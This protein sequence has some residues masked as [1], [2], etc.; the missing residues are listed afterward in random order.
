MKIN[1]TFCLD[2]DVARELRKRSNQS[3]LVNQLL[4]RYMF[5]Q[6]NDQLLSMMKTTQIAAAL[7]ARVQDETMKAVL[8][9]FISSNRDVNL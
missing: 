9:S 8:A 2:V 4:K 5:D 6:G 7:H 1:R 3:Y